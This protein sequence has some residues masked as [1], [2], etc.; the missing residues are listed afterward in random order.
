MLDFSGSRKNA[1]QFPIHNSFTY[2][3]FIFVIYIFFFPSQAQAQ[4]E[5]IAVLEFTGIGVD[6]AILGK[7][8]DQSRIVSA[9]FLP[10][11]DYLIMTKENMLE[12]L[13]DMD[14]DFS[15]AV[16]NCEIEIGRNIGADYIISGNILYLEGLYLLTLKLHETN[17]GNLLSGQEI[18]NPSLVELITD[19]QKGSA[20]L[21]QQGLN[22]SMPSMITSEATTTEKIP[23]ITTSSKQVAK[24]CPIQ[25]PIQTVTITTSYILINENLW[26]LTSPSLENQFEKM[27]EECGQYEALTSFLLWRKRRKNTILWTI[28]IVGSYSV[29][30]FVGV[31]ALK[32]RQQFEQDLWNWK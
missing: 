29:A 15:C 9:N 14:K 19:V 24:T 28:T 30:P 7:L 2:M 16:G 13:R 10:P 18:K 8:S 11:D 31:S 26:H 12:I 3:Y 23:V 22:I 32:S 27:L 5:R 1:L 21:L 4:S 6:D 17:S 20:E 25:A